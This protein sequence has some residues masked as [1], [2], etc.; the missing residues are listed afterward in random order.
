MEPTGIEPVTSTMPLPRNWVVR[1]W[2]LALGWID[3]RDRLL[4]DGSTLPLILAGLID[5]E[6]DDPAAVIDRAR[7][8]GRLSGAARDRGGLPAIA[9][10]RRTGRGRCKTV[11]RC[12]GMARADSFVSMLL[13]A[14][15]GQAAAGVAWLRG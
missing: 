15:I 7:R 9:R 10:T 8:R 3:L 5:A 14:L 1:W 4:P 2:L 11:C 6:L 12:R 13:A